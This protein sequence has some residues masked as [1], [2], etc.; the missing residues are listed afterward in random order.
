VNSEPR[1]RSGLIVLDKPSGPTSHD[2]VN[3]VRKTLGTRSVGHAGTL[4]P[5]ASGVLLVMVGQCTKLSRFLTLEQKTYLAGVR[6]GLQTDTLDATGRV[7]QRSELPEQLR[8][9]LRAPVARL[10]AQGVVAEAIECERQRTA[11]SPPVYSAIKQAGMACY[12][13]AR[14]GQDVQLQQRPVQVFDLQLLSASALGDLVFELTVS[15]GYYVRAFARDIG[16]SLQVPAHLFSLRRTRSG[17]FGLQGAV[18][19]NASPSE[20]WERMIE[21]PQ[22][23]RSLM[24]CAELTETGARRALWGQCLDDTDFRTA[25]ADGLSAWFAP[26]GDLV[27]VGERI[28][29][30]PT[31]VRAFSRSEHVC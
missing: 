1:T 10:N 24:R 7:A 26:S 22:V 20:L 2:V 14:R 9:Q 17:P 23:A 15:K 16:A 30:R 11:Q 3:W 25:P 6:L 12:E 18:C 21:M 19:T 28:G 13:R 4:D 27:A 8:E 5:A 31:V 29:G